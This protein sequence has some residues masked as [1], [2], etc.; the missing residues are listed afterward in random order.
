MDPVA[1]PDRISEAARTNTCPRC[2]NPLP[3]KAAIG[4]GDPKDGRFCSL[5]CVAVFHGDTF[6]ERRRRRLDASKN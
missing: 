5:D 3:E 4:T 1:K 6:V 2:E